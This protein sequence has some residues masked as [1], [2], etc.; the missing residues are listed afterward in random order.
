MNIDE[1]TKF[2]IKAY[3]LTGFSGSDLIDHI[4]EHLS[5]EFKLHCLGGI[6]ELTEIGDK[7]DYDHLAH[8]YGPCDGQ[9]TQ[10]IWTQD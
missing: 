1:A 7:L 5:D 3:L 8:K 9:D 10:T 4:W 6:L 2:K